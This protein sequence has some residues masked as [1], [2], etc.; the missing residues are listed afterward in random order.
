MTEDKFRED[1]IMQQEAQHVSAPRFSRFDSD[2]E[3]IAWAREKI[4]WAVRA[5]ERHEKHANDARDLKSGQRWHIVAG[6]MRRTLLGGQGCAIAAF[7][8][9]LPEWV[10]RIEAAGSEQP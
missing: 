7:D 1:G 2:P 6:F 10:G 5:A 3:A 8:E 4:K 9:R